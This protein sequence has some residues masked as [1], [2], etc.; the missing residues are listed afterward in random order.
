MTQLSNTL[1]PP[2]VDLIY[3]GIVPHLPPN[4]TL[5]TTI[6][7]AAQRENHIIIMAFTR[8]MARRTWGRRAP[9]S[10]RKTRSRFPRRN[11]RK[12]RSQAYSSQRGNTSMAGYRGRKVPYRRYLN[13]MWRSSNFKEHHRSINSTAIAMTS[14]VSNTAADVFIT[15]MITNSFWSTGGGSIVNLTVDEDIFIRGGVA[16][17]TYRNN[18]SAPV[19][20]RTYKIFRHSAEAFSI[21]TPQSAMWD[22][23][24]VPNFERFYNIRGTFKTIIEPG[25]QNTINHYI[26][27]RK[28]EIG[29]F[30]DGYRRD[31]WVTTI[32]S[33][34]GAVVSVTSLIGHSISFVV[35][36]L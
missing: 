4:V 34:N 33:T 25:D 6:N 21:P 15:P 35:D 31:Y 29:D 26:G 18:G 14:N 3:W 7:K 28:V 5:I 27:K 10:D 9:R 20:V 19:T 16:N 1:L 23:T 24:T 36:R 12:R 30:N 2:R 8:S 13:Q 32:N 17:I 11:F 22:P